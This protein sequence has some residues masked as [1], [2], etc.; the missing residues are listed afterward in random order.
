ML[1]SI[2]SVKCEGGYIREVVLDLGFR[3][4]S[5]GYAGRK[6]LRYSEGGENSH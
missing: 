3:R 2:R 5:A 1:S 4:D 6:K